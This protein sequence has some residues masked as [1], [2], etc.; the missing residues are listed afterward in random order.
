MKK[1]KNLTKAI[2]IFLA[3]ALAVSVL[4]VDAFALSGERLGGTASPVLCNSGS[5]AADALGESV[6]VEALREYLFQHFYQYETRIDISSFEIPYS[7]DNASAVCNFIFYEMPEAFQIT[8]MSYYYSSKYITALVP[9]YSYTAEEY[10]V[11]YTEF[12]SGANK[13]LQG[14]KDNSYLSQEEKALLLHDRLALWNEYDYDNYLNNS[15]PQ[16]SYD[17]YGV[18]AKRTAVCKGYA[19]AYMYLL[20]QVGIK[21]EYCS[22]SS[23][24]HAW[25]IVYINSIPYHVDVTWDDPVRD[26]TGR[27][28]HENFLVSSDMLYETG[29]TATDYSTTPQDTRYDDYYWRDSTT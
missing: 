20:Y 19:L 22:S 6:D 28:S 5:S 26:I 10:A 13:L 1:S 2:S 21:S 11:M 29:H 3:L 17:A 7:Q 18:F 24:N 8:G 27:V 12:E 16:S 15:I 25:N 23:L 14:I 9:G 4:S